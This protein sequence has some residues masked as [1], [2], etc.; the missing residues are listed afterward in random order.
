MYWWTIKM[1]ALPPSYPHLHVRTLSVAS[2]HLKWHFGQ[3]QRS[4]GL[5]GIRAAQGWPPLWGQRWEGAGVSDVSKTIEINH[6]NLGANCHLVSKTSLQLAK[7]LK[8]GGIKLW[9]RK[10]E[11]LPCSCWVLEK[12]YILSLV[13]FFPWEFKKKNALAPKPRKIK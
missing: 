10:T 1:H 3:L 11:S 12:Q 5:H 9:E 13:A 4:H 8:N 2:E 6:E 7:N